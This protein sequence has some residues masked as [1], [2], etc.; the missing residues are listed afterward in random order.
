[1]PGDYAFIAARE[2][3]LLLKTELRSQIFN[4]VGGILC[5]LL[6]VRF[7]RLHSSM[8]HFLKSL[9][10]CICFLWSSRFYLPSFPFLLSLELWNSPQISLMFFPGSIFLPVSTTERLTHSSGCLS[11]IT[12]GEKQLCNFS[13]IN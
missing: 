8:V 1:M 2:S 3:V 9:S 6:K 5:W 13:C 4:S 11:T 12:N 10:N 7:K